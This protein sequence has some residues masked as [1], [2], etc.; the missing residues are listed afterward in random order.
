M[1]LRRIKHSVDPDQTSDTGVSCLLK[2][3]SLKM[4]EQRHAKTLGLNESLK[5]LG[6]GG[7]GGSS[8]STREYGKMISSL[9]MITI[10]ASIFSCRK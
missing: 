1:L 10:S 4:Y 8:L 7:G 5:L 6:G 9:H 3:I 2:P